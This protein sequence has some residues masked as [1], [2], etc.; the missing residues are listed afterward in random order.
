[1]SKRIEIEVEPL[2]K[3]IIEKF[4]RI[5]ADYRWMENPKV[6]PGDDVINLMSWL[7]SNP[8]ILNKFYKYIQSTNKTL[9]VSSQEKT[10]FVLKKN[11]LPF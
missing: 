6:V 10:I 11:E 7:Y 5:L 3:R 2:S 8:K 4:E 9:V 1:M